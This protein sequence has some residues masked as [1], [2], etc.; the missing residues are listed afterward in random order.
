M[1]S[2]TKWR[3]GAKARFTNGPINTK[4]FIDMERGE[5]RS[6][7]SLF[8]G[9]DP[10]YLPGEDAFLPGSDVRVVPYYPGK[11]SDAFKALVEVE[12]C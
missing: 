12:R 10:A 11:N 6:D 4:T 9:I 7:I 1:S 5:S 2:A 8:F 3:S